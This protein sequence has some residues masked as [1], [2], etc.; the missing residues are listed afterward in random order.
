MT[1]FDLDIALTRTGAGR[2]ETR[3][4]DSWNVHIGPNGGYIAA[5]ILNGIKQELGNNGKQ[6]RSITF[7]FLSASTPGPATLEVVPEKLG[8][9]LS[10]ATA[11]LVQG[12]RTI[13]LAIATFADARPSVEFCDFKAP[14]VDPPEAIAAGARM[15]PGMQGHVPFRDHYDQRLAIGPVPP[16]TSGQGHV[17]GWTRFKELR[18]VDDLA[19]VAISDSWFPSMMARSL[20]EK[21]HAPTVDH[22][23]HFMTSLPYQGMASDDFMLVEFRTEVASEGYLIEDG[24]MWAPDGTLL[25]RSR[26]LAIIMKD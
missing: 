8:R 12:Q 25:A 15:E 13:A 19:L 23:V 2:F 5:L 20:P 16:S 21:L 17:G 3:I 9:T 4:G 11:K 10:T 1:R 22:S 7:H 24:C 18:A 14:D 26:Q 6:T